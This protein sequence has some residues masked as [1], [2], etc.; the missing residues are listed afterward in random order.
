MRQSLTWEKNMKRVLRKHISTW[1]LLSLVGAIG[2]AVAAA[3]ALNKPVPEFLVAIDNLEP[4]QKLSSAQ[5]AT[6]PIDLGDSGFSYMTPNEFEEGY[7]VTDFI[8]SGELLP[9]RQLSLT[10]KPGM[11]TLVLTPA[12]EISPSIVP[13]SWIQIWRTIEG[14]DGFLSE[15]VVERSQVVSV[16]KDE[17]LVSGSMAQ[18]EVEVSEEQ[19][20]IILQSISAEQDIYVLVTL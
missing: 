10:Q 2:L 3:L 5:L 20:S 12:L 6:R 15:R 16:I 8:S 11:T 19:S 4:G 18:L 9:R 17:S 7:V 13:G 14:P 1:S